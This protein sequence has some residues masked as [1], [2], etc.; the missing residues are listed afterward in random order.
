MK[1][2]LL[3]VVAEAKNGCVMEI[4]LDSDGTGDCLGGPI[5]C[6]NGGE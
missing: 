4:M 2:I 6:L 5:G 3:V 1:S